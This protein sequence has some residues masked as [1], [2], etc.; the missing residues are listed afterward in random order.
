MP[1]YLFQNPTTGEIREFIFSMNDEK[2]V[3]QDNVEWERVFTRPNSSIDTEV[4]PFSPKDFV[5]ATTK[6][7]TYGAMMDRSAEL[8]ERRKEKNG[9][10]DPVKEK[11]Y[12]DYSTTRKG[13][14]HP[15]VIKRES[16]ERLNKLGVS[17]S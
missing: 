3:F 12:Q 10:I 15:D 5:K 6:P 14:K 11:Y 16:K 4:D 7:D 2:R 9:G 17:I 1:I 13:A 8:S